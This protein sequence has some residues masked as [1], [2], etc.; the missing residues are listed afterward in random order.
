MNVFIRTSNGR[1]RAWL[2][3]ATTKKKLSNYFEYLVVNRDSLLKEYYEKYAL[4]YTENANILSGL[5]VGLNSFDYDVY[6]KDESFD[7]ISTS[8]D[9]ECYLKETLLSNGDDNT[10]QPPQA[11]FVTIF[12]LSFHF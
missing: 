12:L 2:R 9:L 3:L 10:Q 8:L 5:L 7:N 1:V 6:L 11:K 4:I